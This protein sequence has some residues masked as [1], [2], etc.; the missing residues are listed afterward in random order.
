[1][2]VIMR[3]LKK[4]SREGEG[5]S[6]SLCDDEGFFTGK[7]SYIRENWLHSLFGGGGSKKVK[8][9]ALAVLFV[10][11]FAISFYIWTKR[12]KPVP[13]PTELAEFNES[14]K[15]KDKDEGKANLSKDEVSLERAYAEYKGGNFDAAIDLFKKLV[16]SGGGVE[17]I[18]GLGLS[19]LKKGL[20]SLAEEEFRKGIELNPS[21][22]I[23]FNNLGYLLSLKGDVAEAKKSLERSIAL[24]PNYGDPHFNMA[25]LFEKEGDV[26][27]A[28]WHYKK[29]LELRGGVKDDVGDMVTR[30][31]SE[32][33][34]E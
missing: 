23:C 30:R 6:V 27:S 24:D 11:L 5:E 15:T 21:C 34:G 10:S 1:M 22:A 18:N 9:A 25:V 2:S 12:S 26:R 28:V 20:Y 8:L 19:Y 32:L 13:P 14:L 33:G 16:E 17:A 3:A 31:I 7:D 29:F 4:Q